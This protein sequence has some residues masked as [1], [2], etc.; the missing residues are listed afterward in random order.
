MTDN[1]SLQDGDLLS[2]AGATN[3]QISGN[4]STRASAW[5]LSPT[6][7][8]RPQLELLD[9]QQEQAHRRRGRGHLR[10]RR[11]A[12]ELDAEGQHDDGKHPYGI[13]LST[14]NTGNT[15]RNNNF[16]NLGAAE[17]LPGRLGGTSNT[18]KKDKGK[19]RVPQGICKK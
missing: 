13:H 2:I 4:S 11:V 12:D 16:K 18:W 10:R 5:D 14:G 3:S 7:R 15:I 17:R 9:D 19:R 6:R 1:A 8:V